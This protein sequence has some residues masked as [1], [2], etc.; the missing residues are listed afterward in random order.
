MYT[1]YVMCDGHLSLTAFNCVFMGYLSACSLPA[2][3]SVWL[4]VTRST[5]VKG[6]SASFEVG[7][8]ILSSSTAYLPSGQNL[9]SCKL[10][11]DKTEPSWVAGR[12]SDTNWG[13]GILQN[14]ISSQQSGNKQE[15]KTR[16]QKL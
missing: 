13:F 3:I 14:D 16:R 11:T 7:E 4:S 1:P 6:V 5:A 9:S 12:F 2:L 15:A 10:D 8:P